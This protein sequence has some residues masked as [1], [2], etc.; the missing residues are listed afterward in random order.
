MQANRASP[1]LATSLR[2]CP[3]SD[4]SPIELEMYPTVN[5]AITNM[6]FNAIPHLNALDTEELIWCS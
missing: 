2:L 1:M 4:I 3:A 6:K 5:S